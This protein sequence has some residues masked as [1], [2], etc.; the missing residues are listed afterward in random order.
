MTGAICGASHGVEAFPLAAR[1]TV[2]S[3][4]GLNLEELATGLLTVRA[5]GR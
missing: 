1:D 3:V 2:A 4:N 5:G